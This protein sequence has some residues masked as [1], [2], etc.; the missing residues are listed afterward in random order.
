MS[1]QSSASSAFSTS[2]PAAP[3]PPVADRP[4]DRFAFDP[5]A[6]NALASARRGAYLTADPFPHAVF[7]D[8][9]PP[10]VVRALV[11]AFPRPDAKIFRRFRDPMQKKLASAH[12]NTLPEVVRR[13]LAEF[14][15]A[16]FLDFLQRLTGIDGL[17]TDPHFEGGGVHQIE[18]GGMLKVHADFNRHPRLGLDR[19]INA[20]LYLNEDWTDADGGHL[21][22]WDRDMTRRAQ[23]VLPVANRL[24]IFSTTDFSFHGHPEPLSCAE[25][26]TRKSLAL[27]YYSNGRPQ[28]ELQNIAT[29]STVFRRR[30]GE[31]ILPSVHESA[32]LLLPPV[33]LTGVERLRAKGSILGSRRWPAVRSWFGR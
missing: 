21:E 3:K 31:R 4:S 11:D 16:A 1:P 24:V 18:R 25:G 20:L 2:A 33:L 29:R 5:E 23:R 10:S 19:R 7:D 12:P 32:Q 15:S 22:L 14:N 28:D 6:L 26:R 30:P 17:I 27:Y 9:L 8:F 13:V